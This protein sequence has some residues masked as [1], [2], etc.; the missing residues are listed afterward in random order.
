MK[1]TLKGLCAF[2]AAAGLCFGAAV[3]SQAAWN[4]TSYLNDYNTAVDVPQGAVL[5]DNEADRAPDGTAYIKASDN[6]SD[7]LK[8]AEG[9]DMAFE[10]LAST[11]ALGTFCTWET[12]I[13][14]TQTDAGFSIRN[15]TGA[16]SG[17]LNTTIVLGSDN[18]LRLSSANGS[19][20][21]SDTINLNEWY[22]IKLVGVYGTYDGSVTLTVSK[23]NTDG[24]LT[25]VNEV[26]EINRRNNKTATRFVFT[27]GISVDN[28]NVYEM[29]PKG[30]ELTGTA[31]MTAG[32]SQQF[33]YQLYADNAKTMPMSGMDVVYELYNA[34]ATEYL[35]SD[36]ITITSTGGLLTVSGSAEAQSFVVR[37]KCVDFPEVYVDVEVNVDSV[38]MLEF[39]GA[40][41]DDVDN[42]TTLVNLKFKQG[43]EN[44]GDITFV[45]AV[46]DAN[47]RLMNAYTKN[48][49]YK[50]QQAGDLTV[51]LNKA[52]PAEFDKDTCTIKVF[53]W[54]KTID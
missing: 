35:I 21:F 20:I 46:F 33:S 13:K 17:N 14:F 9:S 5:V 30:L 19:R 26:K 15:N 43:Y 36:D 12:D 3:V 18:T 44:E 24:S 32:E 29:P 45:A 50:D 47:N 25:L 16:N 10:A 23:Y 27:P 51:T 34:D 39:I 2:A 40:S 37:A 49:A 7:W 11:K 4:G 28:V 6:M 42:P 38:A 22:H 8:A 54:T 31:S 48:L 1:R 53:A 52:L 41:F